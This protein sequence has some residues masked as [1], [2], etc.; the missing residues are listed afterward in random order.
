VNT[1]SDKSIFKFLVTGTDDSALVLYSEQTKVAQQKTDEATVA[2]KL[3]VHRRRQLEAEGLDERSLRTALAHVEAAL[4][5][6]QNESQDADGEVGRFRRRLRRIA[7]FRDL[8]NTRV[9]ELDALLERFKLLDQ[10]YASDIE[11]LTAIAE[12]AR[13][14]EAIAPGPCPLCGAPPEA[15][16]PK[17]GCD[18]D[19]VALGEAATAEVKRIERLRA[20]LQPTIDKAI[21]EKKDLLRRADDAGTQAA[22]VN[23]ELGSALETARTQRASY[24][25]VFQR[26]AALK[27]NL[28]AFDAVKDFEQSAADLK[29]EA[30]ELVPEM[31]DVA[32]SRASTDGFA[33]EVAAILKAWNV[34]ETERVAFDHQAYDL[35]LNGRLRGGQGKGLRALT[36]AAFSIALM[37]YCLKNAR[38]HPGFV[39]L[40]SPLL[41]YRG[42][43]HEPDPTQ[44]L[45]STTV[46]QAFYRW[47]AKD[48]K[49]GQVIV[50][51]N[52]DP[53][54]NIRARIHLHE[55]LPNAKRKGFIPT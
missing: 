24:A 3:L 41:S 25:E 14:L 40:D 17:S 10:H 2:Q 38:P 37:T 44:D 29:R 7:E 12:A 42:E 18:G 15:H 16:Q 31:P 23:R 4:A 47:L 9:K 50:I 27:E 51:E 55:F 49:H 43:E 39:V 35:Q 36:H 8:A 54:K 48:L 22:G 26:W 30:D 34:P 11:R 1:T 45:K 13:N 19:L 32:I 52:R 20:D 53:P 5:G 46:D 33:Q 6:V 28:R 21:S